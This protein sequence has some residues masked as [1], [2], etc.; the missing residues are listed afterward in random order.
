MPHV[1]GIAWANPAAV[2]Y[3][4]V[5]GQKVMKE[6]IKPDG[7]FNLDD[8]DFHKFVDRWTTCSLDTGN[9]KLDLIVKKVQTH[10]HKDYSCK[11]IIHGEEVCR[12]DYP[13]LPS[14]KTI[15]AKPLS[16]EDP[17]RESKLKKAK[18]IKNKVKKLIRM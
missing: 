8:E 7:T 17:N 1:H 3:V 18:F 2:N 6:F 12:F 11:R 15:I 4:M 9:S 5:N 16:S 13:K 14:Q 10:E